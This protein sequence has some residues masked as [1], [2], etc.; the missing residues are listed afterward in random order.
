VN[1]KRIYLVAGEVSGD[2][3]GAALM[4]ALN[5]ADSNLVLAATGGPEMASVAGAEVDDWLADA[6]VLGLWE[7][8]KKYGYFRQQ[9][10]QLVDRLMANPP[11]ALVLID[12]PGFNL[13]L[14]DALRKRDYCGKILYYISPQVWAWKKGRIPK[15]ARLLD[16]MVCL[17]PFEVPIFENSG[18]KA[19]CSGHPLMDELSEADRNPHLVGLLPGSREHEVAKLF[20]V[21]LE[22]AKSLSLEQPK[23][24]FAT[25][26]ASAERAEQ[27]RELLTASGLEAELV[28]IRE[29]QGAA[30]SIMATAQAAAVAS[31][32]ATLESAAHGLPYCLCYQV[33]WLTYKVGRM[34]VELDHIGMANILVGREVVREL[35]QDECTPA[36]VAAELKRLLL[37]DTY[38]AHVQAGVL[39]ARDRLGGPGASERAAAAMLSELAK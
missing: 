37:D 11:D 12:Y 13:R 25:A 33:S 23:L 1:P 18:L 35:L 20:P 10:D 16:L 7:V 32:T 34:V 17:F 21:M 30:R 27:M 14:A 31:G 28:D 4:R 26:A 22:A 3:H 36:S 38:R 6:A 24:R 19:V 8:I 5:K 2:H 15:M 9:M 39:E 29:G